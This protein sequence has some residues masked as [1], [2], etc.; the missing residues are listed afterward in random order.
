MG[1][2]GVCQCKLCK[3]W[4]QDKVIYWDVIKFCTFRLLIRSMKVDTWSK[5]QHKQ[6]DKW[7]QS[8]NLCSQNVCFSTWW[9]KDRK[10]EWLQKIQEVLWTKLTWKLLVMFNFRTLRFPCLDSIHLPSWTINGAV[11]K[12][13]YKVEVI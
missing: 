13:S 6:K 9:V 1:H 11:V 7:S 8:T 5:S 2:S 12:A 3:E 4:F 10:Q